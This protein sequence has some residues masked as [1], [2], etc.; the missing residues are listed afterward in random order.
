MIKLRRGSM[1]RLI[2][3]LIALFTA[4]AAS[5]VFLLLIEQNPFTVFGTL[6]AFSLGRAD[7]IGAL[8]FNATPLIFP[9][10]HW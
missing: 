5:S 3:P 6:L 7:S 8:L 9:D 4:M 1:L 10:W 2:A